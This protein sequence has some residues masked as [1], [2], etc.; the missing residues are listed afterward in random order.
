LNRFSK[1]GACSYRTLQ[2]SRLLKSV[3]ILMA[4][5]WFSYAQALPFIGP[6]YKVE[7]EFNGN[8]DVEKEITKFI[9]EQQKDNVQLKAIVD[10]VESDDRMSRYNSVL[11][12]SI[13][14]QLQALGYYNFNLAAKQQEKTLFYRIK[15][16]EQSLIKQIDIKLPQFFDAQQKEALNKSLL[17]EQFK[18]DE[19]LVAATVIAAQDR[20]KRYIDQNY[21]F[22]NP[23][24]T[25]QVSLVRGSRSA[26]V[27]FILDTKQ[28]QTIESIEF[29]GS[30]S[31]S[32]DFLR[33]VISLKLG[34]Y[35]SRDVAQAQVDLL[36]TGLLSAAVPKIEQLADNKV[37]LIFNLQERKH[38]TQQIGLGF[39]TDEGPRL[40]LG[41]ENRNWR[42]NGKNLSADFKI[43]SITTQLESELRVPQFKTPKLSL[44]LQGELLETSV[45]AFD[46]SSARLSALL[47]YQASRH[48]RFSTGVTSQYSKIESSTGEEIF[49]LFSIPTRVQWDHSDDLLDPTRGFTWTLGVEPFT[50]ITRPEIQFTQFI[51]S[52]RHYYS[53]RWAWGEDKLKR[54]TFASRV[55]TGAIRGESLQSVPADQRYYTG[56]G[57]SVRG[58]DYQSLSPVAQDL[59][60]AVAGDPNAIVGGLSF[61]EV[62]G[63]LR[64]RFTEQWGAGLFIDAGR[65]FAEQTPD[66]GAELG[67]GG[68]IGLRYMTSF[69]PIRVDLAWPISSV[70]NNEDGLQLYVGLKQAF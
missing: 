60:P 3:L 16:G 63:E 19:P 64:F 31:L 17:D 57:G 68:G 15:L 8:E 43:S 9:K 6:V 54:V 47:E 24:L 23:K 69:A 10:G 12:E 46:S 61:F 53:P 52:F 48:W 66:F 2:V 13:R 41:W 22:I 55:A 11:A 33:N 34:C 40:T 38:K 50:D 7:L 32:S 5:L 4:C 62:A 28:E 14:K 42:G 70:N 20:L 65:G 36:Q 51:T 59:T 21:C 25:Q 49:R 39:S 26:G 45:D 37:K 67:I 29:A 58:F 27:K 35:K 44:L 30:E 1:S 18:V 56:G